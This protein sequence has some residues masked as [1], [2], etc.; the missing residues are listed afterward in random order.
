MKLMVAMTLAA[1][2]VI[3]AGMEPAAGRVTV[4][5]GYSLPGIVTNSAN[6]V[7]QL[8]LKD[9]P[10]SDS[11]GLIGDFRGAADVEI[12]KLGTGTLCL[13]P[14]GPGGSS[15]PQPAICA[16]GKPRNPQD[17]YVFDDSGFVIVATPIQSKITLSNL[18]FRAE[19][20]T[21]QSNSNISEQ[22]L[23]SIFAPQQAKPLL[24][25]NVFDFKDID[26][27]LAV[28]SLSYI[29]QKNLLERTINGTYL[30]DGNNKPLGRVLLQNQFVQEVAEPSLTLG[31]LAA[32]SAGLLLKRK[33]KQNLT[34]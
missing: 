32:V 3:S 30:E 15:S 26:K 4:G 25:F 18:N 34:D 23:Y 21:D 10:N 8:R 33:I 24:T 14:N 5:N 29:L 13:N 1:V 22:I 28:N 27:N 16:T 20:L 19:L 2:A 7:V 17:V 6:I 31:A 9:T 12:A 11:T